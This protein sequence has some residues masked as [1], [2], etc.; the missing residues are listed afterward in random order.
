[1][2]TR[3]HAP[4]NPRRTRARHGFLAVLAA[5]TLAVTAV[6]ATASAASTPASGPGEL[7]GFAPSALHPLPG[8]WTN[9]RAW[10]IEY[11]ST[12]A[13]GHPDTVSGTVIVPQDG[14]TAPRPLITYAVGT[15]GLADSCAPSANF[16]RGTAL[17]ANLIQKLTQRGWAVAV[18]DYEGLGTPGDHTYTV[19]RSAGRAML[20]AARAA[21]QL[22]EAGLSADGPVGIMGYSQGGQAASWAAEL[23]GSYAPEL[24]VKG[25]AAGGVPAD[26]MRVAASNDGS[27]GSGLIF[28]AAAGQDAAFPELDLDSYLNPAGRVLV[29][30]FRTHCVAVDAALGS[31]KRISDLTTRNPLEQPDWQL[32]LDGST[33]GRTAPDHPVYQYHALADELIPYGVGR[34]LRNDWCARGAT[35]NWSTVWIGEHVSGAI[36]EANRAGDWLADRFAGR[37]VRGNC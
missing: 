13:D 24:K 16:P 18:T 29:D 11:R 7:L 25:T 32:R 30:Y 8:Q 9:T 35:V 36:T 21:Q 14:R 19:G 10:K 4:P 6:P 2:Q 17:E 37:T 31:F 1:M 20:D 33:L 23:H 27:Y 5:L 34:Q 15:V 12:T 26:L 3:F 28:M 22:P